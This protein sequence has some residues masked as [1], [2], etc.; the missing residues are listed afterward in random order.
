MTVVDLLR[1]TVR[2]QRLGSSAAVDLALPAEM[3]LGEVMPCVVDLVGRQLGEGSSGCTERWTLSRL[4]GSALTE[5]MTLDENGVREG[6]LL[7]LTAQA[8]TYAR[9]FTDMS[10]YVVDASGS[11]DHDA[12]WS[13]QL[14]VLTWA[15]SAGV[16]GVT[17]VV[18]SHLAHGNRAVAAA[19]VTIAATVAA[20]IA[21]RTEPESFV[22]PSFGMTAVAFGAVA[23]YLMVP[24]GPAPPNFFLAAAICSAISTVLLHAASRGSTLFIAIATLSSAVAITAAIATVWPIATATLGAAMAAASLAMLSLAAKVS[25]FLTRLSP[26][27]PDGSDAPDDCAPLPAISGVVRA[28]RGHRVL[29]GLLAGFSSSAALGTVLTIADRPADNNTWVRF[30]F[31]AAIAV[32]LIFRACQLR[33]VARRALVLVAGLISVTAA[34]ALVVASDPRHAFWVCL[35]VVALGAGA[36]WLTRVAFGSR[37]SPFARRGVEAVDYLALAAVVP[38]AGWICGVF[39]LVRGLGLT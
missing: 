11:P 20:V 15:W 26:Q 2:A 17:L 18:P 28:E 6:D 38:M 1:I 31:V 32:A 30:A 5:S 39:G 24:G 25:I 33:G 4:D 7:L 16:G 8:L 13:R 23:G 36:L 37:L 9:D 19:I 22:T 10:H 27:M 29:T 21:G 14:G 34:F 35:V 12:G 3:E